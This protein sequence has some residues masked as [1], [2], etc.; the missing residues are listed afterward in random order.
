MIGTKVVRTRLFEKIKVECMEY[1]M[2][3]VYKIP[4]LRIPKS[5]SGLGRRTVEVKE[6]Y[7]EH[8]ERYVDVEASL[9]WFSKNFC[10]EKP[11]DAKV[12]KTSG[13]LQANRTRDR[14]L[15]VYAK[16]DSVERGK[17]SGIS[18]RYKLSKNNKQLNWC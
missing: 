1:D 16:I 3:D 17:V 7:E 5:R 11:C 13:H 6:L 8:I 2:P 14:Q 18:M 4:M 10:Y 9:V 12:L 15:R